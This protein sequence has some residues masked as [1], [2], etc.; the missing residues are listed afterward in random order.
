MAIA[1]QVFMNLDNFVPASGSYTNNVAGTTTFTI[2]NYRYLIVRVWGGGGGAANNGSVGNAGGTTSFGSFLSATGGGGGTSGTSGTGGSG[3]TG[4]SGEYNE[5]G[6]SGKNA[7]KGTFYVNANSYGG[8]AANTSNGGG[9]RRTTTYVSANV[10]GQVGFTYGGGG[11]GAAGSTGTGSF[12]SLAGGGGGG[13]STT[14]FGR[15]EISV[16]TVVSLTI[17]A[18]GTAP[19]SS[20]AGANGAIVIIWS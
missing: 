7:N 19:G 5:T 2:P 14:E 9:A 8:A 20:G 4:V 1:Q 13:Y 10:A 15:G 12:A 18:A 6:E 3:G 17:G 16:G 11:S